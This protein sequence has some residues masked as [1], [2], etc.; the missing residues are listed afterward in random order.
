MWIKTV[1]GEINY[2]TLPNI[3]SSIYSQGVLKMPISGKEMRKLYK[4][5]G[6]KVERI[7]GSHHFMTKGK[8]VEII[9]VHVK[10]LGKGL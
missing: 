4:R 5:A 7:K 8:S 10:D 2:L 3:F 9:P 1:H 6:W